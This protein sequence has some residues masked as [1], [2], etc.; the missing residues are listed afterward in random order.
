[1]IGWLKNWILDSKSEKYREGRDLPKWKP[2]VIQ[3]QWPL[4][5]NHGRK[6]KRGGE[7]RSISCFFF[8]VR[9]FCNQGSISQMPAF[10][11]ALSRVPWLS[12]LARNPWQ[13]RSCRTNASSSKVEAPSYAST[14][15]IGSRDTPRS[16]DSQGLWYLWLKYLG[17]ARFNC[18]RSSS[19]QPYIFN[20]LPYVVVSVLPIVNRT[21]VSQVQYPRIIFLSTSH[22]NNQLVQ[23][24]KIIP[25]WNELH[26][27]RNLKN[28]WVISHWTM[29]LRKE[30]KKNDVEQD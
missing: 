20:G 18:F 23:C 21:S 8:S 30:Y 1:M 4:S 11:E 7:L 22:S 15:D 17:C 28:W 6:Q 12:M 3:A 25:D 29:K 27:T 10:C 2:C 9:I 14:T 5:N 26:Q 16:K 13:R 24:E 19:S